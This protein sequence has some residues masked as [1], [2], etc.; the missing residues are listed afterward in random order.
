MIE[1]RRPL[2][3]SVGLGHEAADRDG[4]AD[5]TPSTDLAADSDDLGRQARDLQ[6]V[7]VGLGRQ[8]AHEVQL[9]LSPSRAVGGGNRA[10]EVFLGYL[11]IDHLAHALTAALGGEGEATAT[12]VARQ[13][14][15]K[16][17]VEGVYASAR[18]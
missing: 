7:F 11:L 12:T 9:H 10:D 16:V 17:D 15:G 2:E 6:D 8:P 14:I 4:A 13:F 5:V 1:L 18:Q 3:G